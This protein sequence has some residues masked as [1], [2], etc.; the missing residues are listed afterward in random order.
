MAEKII[1]PRPE[2]LAARLAQREP[3]MTLE[4]LSGLTE[5]SVAQLQRFGTGERE[6][7]IGEAIKLAIAL[8]RRFEELFPDVYY[9]GLDTELAALMRR[10]QNSTSPATRAKVT[11]MIKVMLDDPSSDVGA[12]QPQR[13]ES[14]ALGIPD[15]LRRP[16]TDA[17][18]LGLKIS[19]EHPDRQLEPEKASHPQEPPKPADHKAQKKI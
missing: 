19:R 13:S 3:K 2:L 8:E 11:K 9:G 4:R 18:R 17:V 14:G 5:I 1:T 7:R 6:P 16:L 15:K 10:L 12:S